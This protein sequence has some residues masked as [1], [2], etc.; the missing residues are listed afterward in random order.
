MYS[1]KLRLR[2]IRPDL[3]E[4]FDRLNAHLTLVDGIE[5][6]ARERP[7]GDVLRLHLGNPIV[8][9]VVEHSDPLGRLLSGRHSIRKGLHR[10]QVALDKDNFGTSP[11]NALAGISK[12][13]E[14]TLLRL[15]SLLQ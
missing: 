1:Q 12:G 9:R 4:K 15:E 5:R 13:I 2:E 14:T 3:A 6:S 8:D 10:V 7:I 11:E